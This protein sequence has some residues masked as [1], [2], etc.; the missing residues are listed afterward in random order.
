MYSRVYTGS[1]ACS[2]CMDTSHSTCPWN[3]QNGRRSLARYIPPSL[4]SSLPPSVY[5]LVCVYIC[6]S[7]CYYQLLEWIRRT[8]PWL[9]T[10][11]TDNTVPGCRRKLAEFR[12]YAR[13]RKPPKVDQKA[14]LESTFNTLQTRL[15]L[16]NRPAYM[17]TEGKMVSVR[18]AP[19]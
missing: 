13:A 5:V 4:P 14:K 12:D 2:R 9:E 3:A 6:P 17:P 15:R 19:S 8:R 16:S 18:T 1:D 10:R 7:V 11:T